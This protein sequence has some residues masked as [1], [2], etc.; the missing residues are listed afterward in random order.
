[1]DVVNDR[2]AHTAERTTGMR[3][4]ASII[5]ALIASLTTNG[6]I[7]FAMGGLDHMWVIVAVSLIWLAIFLLACPTIYDI[8]SRPTPPD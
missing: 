1:V 7:A 8:A 4:V 5:W 6:L 3:W 2:D